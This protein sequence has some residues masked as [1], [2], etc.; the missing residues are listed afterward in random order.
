[1]RRRCAVGKLL[2]GSAAQWILIDAAY[3]VPAVKA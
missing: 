1:M 3:P 2:L